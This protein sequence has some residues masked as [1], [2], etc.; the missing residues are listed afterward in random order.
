MTKI[1]HN[2]CW[3]PCNRGIWHVQKDRGTSQKSHESVTT[4]TN[5]T[6]SV[7]KGRSEN[8]GF[9][10]VNALARTGAVAWKFPARSAGLQP[11]KGGAKYRNQNTTS[12]VTTVPMSIKD[13][14]SRVW[15]A[16]TARNRSRGR[17]R[18]NSGLT[19]TVPWSV[20]MLTPAIDNTSSR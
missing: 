10:A 15:C 14:T 19:P 2:R 4:V 5:H 13:G 18:I 9:A 6:S 11:T 12:A 8:L 3:F 7:T 17:P 16:I 20:G 1:P